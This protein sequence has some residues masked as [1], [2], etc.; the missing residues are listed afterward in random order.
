[1]NSKQD[2]EECLDHEIYFQKYN[3]LVYTNI[4]EGYILNYASIKIVSE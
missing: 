4:Y 2:A 1:M 3:C